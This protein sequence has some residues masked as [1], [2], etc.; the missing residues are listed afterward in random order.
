MKNII[1]K[2]LTTRGINSKVLVAGTVQRYT[3][4]GH[5][6]LFDFDGISKG[7]VL[8]RC[9]Y[10]EGINILWKSSHTG[11]HLWNL[12]IRSTDEIALLGL[13]LKSD[14]KHI[15]HGYNQ[16]KWVL[17]IVPKFRTDSK[18]N[19]TPYKPAPKLV[20][21]WCNESTYSQS[22]AHFDVFVALTGKTIRQLDS[23]QFEGITAEIED[24]MTMT[25]TMKK[26]VS[27]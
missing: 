3:T 26:G 6:G 2:L 13:R 19:D 1:D 4:K 18:G 27:R 25:D 5:V 9:L 7:E 17:R 11:Y 15:E 21:T 16:R 10:L 24:Y 14:C 12:C 8:A 22:Q 23:Y 20:C